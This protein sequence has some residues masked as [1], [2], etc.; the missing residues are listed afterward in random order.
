MFCC[1]CIVAGIFLSMYKTSKSYWVC[2][3]TRVRGRAGIN[4]LALENLIYILFSFSR[5]EMVRERE[6][7][8]ERERERNTN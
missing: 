1:K 3:V 8:R 4:C 7:E 5:G 6:K 2:Y